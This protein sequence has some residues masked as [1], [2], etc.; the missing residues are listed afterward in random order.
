VAIFKNKW[1]IS[2]KC[3]NRAKKELANAVK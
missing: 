3:R 1:Q 2:G